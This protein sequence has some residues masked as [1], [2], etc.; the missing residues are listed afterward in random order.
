MQP[1]DH[2]LVRVGSCNSHER[3]LSL[4]P[5]SLSHPPN[6]QQLQLDHGRQRRGQVIE[7]VIEQVQDLQVGQ[8]G[9]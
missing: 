4:L 6:V 5:L 7:L 8:V 9:D 1:L 2:T 3:A